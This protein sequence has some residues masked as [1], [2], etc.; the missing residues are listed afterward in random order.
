MGRVPHEG[1]GRKGV[2]QRKA[3]IEGGKEEVGEGGN[4]EIV[5][6]F[7]RKTTEFSEKV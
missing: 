4:G 6:E 3:A 2:R 7:V 5:I 1:I